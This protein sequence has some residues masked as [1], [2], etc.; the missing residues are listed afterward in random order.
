MDFREYWDLGFALR[1]GEEAK[2]A[3]YAMTDLDDTGYSLMQIYQW[4][5]NPARNPELT[6][7]WT[8]RLQ[9]SVCKISG[10]P[11][12]RMHLLIVSKGLPSGERYS[13]R[14]TPCAAGNGETFRK[15]NKLQPD[16]QIL[17]EADFA[18][19]LEGVTEAVN[20]IRMTVGR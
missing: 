13:S 12:D 2:N 11:G 3:A 16:S 8:D 19:S 14:G 7:I 17:D 18:N 15:N 10:F 1:A 9:N 20:W 5:S 4:V 6:P